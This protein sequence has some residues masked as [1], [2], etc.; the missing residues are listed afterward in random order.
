MV[1]V[2]VS[3][4]VFLFIIG[5]LSTVLIPNLPDGGTGAAL[6]GSGSG[7]ATGGAGVGG[8]GGIGGGGVNTDAYT[9]LFF[10]STLVQGLLSGLI[11]GQ[12]STGDIRGGAKH[13]AVLL[14]IAYGVFLLFL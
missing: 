11:A 2:Y 5:V 10:H 13:A 9:L 14:A 3:F 6:S 4:F 12:L 7:G 8:V 1:V